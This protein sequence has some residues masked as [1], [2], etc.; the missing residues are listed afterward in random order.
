MRLKPNDLVL[1]YSEGHLRGVG[2]VEA[3]PSEA[4]RPA[5]F[6]QEPWNQPGFL[7]HVSHR[8]L[9]EPI[10]LTAIPAEWRQAE[11]TLSLPQPHPFTRDG[12][13]VLG[14]LYE[15]SSSFGARL[16]S[17]FPVLFTEGPMDQPSLPATLSP[18]FSGALR[19][20]HRYCAWHR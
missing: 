9:D 1:R 6:P 8:D 16:R 12:A 5:E 4:P 13:V 7:A 10:P 18:E 15:L 3:P 20:A 14:Y 2:T 19:D 17:R 11:A